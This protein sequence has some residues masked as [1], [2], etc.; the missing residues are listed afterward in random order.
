MIRWL[1]VSLLLLVF[2][3][4]GLATGL[5]CEW[6]PGMYWE[7][8][9]SLVQSPSSDG[10]GAVYVLKAENWGDYQVV[11][12]A[13]IWPFSEGEGVQLG[14]AVRQPCGAMRGFGLWA[15]NA[16]RWWPYPPKTEIEQRWT[17]ELTGEGTLHVS[18]LAHDVPVEV[19]AGEFEHCVH[20][21]LT[22]EYTNGTGV[23]HTHEEIWFSRELGWPVKG[24]F[25]L[26][27][28]GEERF[29]LS[30]LG[31][32]EVEQAVAR[33][34]AVVDRMALM[35]A[36]PD[37]AHKIRDQLRSLGLLPEE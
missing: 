7:W 10:R 19:P 5:P 24:T 6:S 14:T 21:V 12:L 4:S 33:V 26:D 27:G 34:L 2:G 9:V 25:L 32:I 13:W 17:S 29:E 28:F 37:Y 8:D 36:P 30:S 3:L 16:H 35:G 23:H 1:A 22:G 31:R 15:S 11:S 18:I 20:L